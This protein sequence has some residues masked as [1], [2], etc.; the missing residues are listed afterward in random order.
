MTPALAKLIEKTTLDQ[1]A[2]SARALKKP[3]TYETVLKMA[4]RALDRAERAIFEAQSLRPSPAAVA[5]GPGCPFCCH[6]R[7]TASAPEILLA[8]DHILSARSADEIAALTRRVKN[9]DAFTRGKTDDERA[10]MRLPCPLL[11]D[12]SCSIHP[13][14]PLSC[15]AVASADKSACVAAYE[16][17]MQSGVPMVDA[18]YQI[19]N[20][21]GYGL[22]AGLA[23]AGFDVENIEM[24]AALALGLEAGDAK[25]LGHR[26]LKGLDPF[27][28][29]K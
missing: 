8:L 25:T 2:D 19:A 9:A 1:R 10:K 13:V 24:N 28:T 6:I 4:G 22:Y 26:W 15:R 23:E 29:A 12:G 27:K 5:C 16:S 18:Q 7:V 20:A 21:V 17:H 3:R 11:K 14:R